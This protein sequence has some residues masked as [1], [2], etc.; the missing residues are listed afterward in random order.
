MRHLAVA[1]LWLQDKVR[2]GDL[3]LHKVLGADNPADVLT[4]YVPQATLDKM[5]KKMRI[6]PETGRADSAAQIAAVLPEDLYQL[7]TAKSKRRR[8][9]AS[10]QG[11]PGKRAIVSQ[12]PAKLGPLEHC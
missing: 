12:D 7:Q 11:R 9:M 4:K 8:H 10:A 5:L 6:E 3:T 2:A 1:D